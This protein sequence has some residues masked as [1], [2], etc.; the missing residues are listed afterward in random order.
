MKSLT[1]CNQEDFI[2]ALPVSKKYFL[3]YLLTIG[4]FRLTS[5]G[6]DSR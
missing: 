2:S 1:K 5:I 4:T 3:F 6:V